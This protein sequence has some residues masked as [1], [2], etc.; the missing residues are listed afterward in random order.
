[1]MFQT[2]LRFWRSTS[3]VLLLLFAAYAVASGPAARLHNADSLIP[4]FVSLESWTLFYWGQ[5]RFGMLLPLLAMSVTDGFWNLMVQNILTV[6]LLLTGVACMFARVEIR[7]T[8]AWALLTLAVLLAFHTGQIR[9]LLL[10]TNQSYGPSL[11][12][13]GIAIYLLQRATWISRAAA[14]T[15]MVLAAW[16]N[17]GVALFVA[18]VALTLVCV[19]ATR[20]AAIPVFA[21]AT[22]SIVAH[23]GLQ[24]FASGPVLDVT[25]IAI[26]AVDALPS[27]VWAFWED[28]VRL[29]GRAYWVTMGVTW[30]AA[31]AIAA[32]RQMTGRPVLLLCG[33]GLATFLY[34][35]AMAAFFHG[36]GRH[37]APAIPLIVM[38]PLIVLARVVPA[39]AD[40]RA[41]SV[42]LLVVVVLQTGLDWPRQVRHQLVERLGQGRAE[43][44]YINNV[45]AVTGDY[46]RVWP[47]TFAVNM[48]HEARDGR[49]PVLPVTRRA[50]RLIKHRRA[51]V[52]ARS[53]VAIVPSGALYYWMGARLPRLRVEAEFPGYA[54]GTVRGRAE[55]ARGRAGAPSQS[56]STPSP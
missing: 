24:H 46:W 53:K 47:W 1:M 23:G 35:S 19:R 30:I 16:T 2:G 41:L 10:T 52:K 22:V 33:V 20:V 18:C 54:V 38:C 5:D 13:F 29:I 31:G 50:E 28:A 43:K 17:G 56:P 15:L 37:I 6:T 27:L 39:L 25:R 9:L 45:T 40:W 8:A 44:L 26:P 7:Q 21:G 42:G 14:V 4:V 3:A 36:L 34:G 49:R 51:D 11:G 12:L 55:D 48:L 32:R